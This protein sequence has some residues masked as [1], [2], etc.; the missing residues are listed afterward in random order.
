MSMR[1]L[2]PHQTHTCRGFHPR[3]KSG[4]GFCQTSARNRSLARLTQQGA[5][6]PLWCGLMFRVIRSLAVISA[7]TFSLA[8]CDGDS[9][10]ATAETIAE[11]SALAAQVLS[12]EGDNLF[13]VGAESNDTSDDTVTPDVVAEQPRV[14]APARAIE[15]A[16]FAPRQPAAALAV[17]TPRPAVKE[18]RVA[19]T[20]RP[21]V[22]R[23]PAGIVSPGS[24]LMMVANQ[25]VCSDAGSSFRATLVDAVRGSNGVMI[26]RGA[27]V[28]AEVLSTDKWGAGISVRARS[29]RIAGRSYPLTSRAGYVLPDRSGCIK[30]R[31]RIEVETIAPLRVMAISD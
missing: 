14:V 20:S 11:D 18:R 1:N 3:R 2:A 15:P 25:R 12:A 24:A 13:A 4:A 21:N 23:G 26:P 29:V 17:V 6:Y 27:Q 28:T 22:S 30:D 7:T 19:R 5:V 31:G 9:P 8:G 10:V 16:I